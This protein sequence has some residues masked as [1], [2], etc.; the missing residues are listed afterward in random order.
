[1]IFKEC[2]CCQ[3]LDKPHQ[4]KETVCEKPKANFVDGTDIERKAWNDGFVNGRLS[5]RKEIRDKYKEIFNH[6]RDEQKKEGNTG[7]RCDIC[8]SSMRKAIEKVMK[9]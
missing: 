6:F 4:N 9:G 1:M 7:C 3:E 2:P 5:E 8:M